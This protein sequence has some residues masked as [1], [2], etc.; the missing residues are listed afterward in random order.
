MALKPSNAPRITRASM[1]RTMRLLN[2]EYKP[3]ELAE[4]LGIST[5]TIYNTYLPAGLP[6]R[7]DKAD[8]IWIVG[9]AFVEWAD[10]VLDKNS[11]SADKRKEPIGE[12][13]GYCMSCKKVTDF[14]TITRRRIMSNN[15]VMVYGA[16]SECGKKMSTFK[17]GLPVGQS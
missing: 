6:H 10:A 17:K 2:M 13:Q 11:R 16:C 7:R 5:K 15:R 1:R 3:S 8:N 12:N 4:E 9:T 14:K